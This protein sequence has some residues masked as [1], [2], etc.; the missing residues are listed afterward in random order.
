MIL[1]WVPSIKENSVL[2]S[3]NSSKLTAAQEDLL[4]R[5]FGLFDIDEDGKLG[6]DD[7]AR[8]R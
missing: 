6:V 4:V 3:I 7:V 2:S 5:C 1:E 8:V